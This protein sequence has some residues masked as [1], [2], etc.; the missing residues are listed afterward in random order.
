M[1]FIPHNPI[2]A[3][4]EAKCTHPGC[5]GRIKFEEAQSAGLKVGDILQY[6]SSNPV[7][8]RCPLCKRHMMKVSLAP[9]PPPPP[10]PKGFS[11]IPKE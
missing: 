1:K 5:V 3:K 7:Y 8:G 11:K 9:T 10:P 2:F 6:Q 4:Y